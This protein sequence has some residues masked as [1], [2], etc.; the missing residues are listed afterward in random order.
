M[1]K[2]LRL[3]FDKVKIDRMCDEKGNNASYVRI[4]YNEF[5][6]YLSYYDLMTCSPLISTPRC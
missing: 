2:C 6:F 5:Y 4:T 3:P 1:Y